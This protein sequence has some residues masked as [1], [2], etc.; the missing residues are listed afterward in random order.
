MNLLKKLK[1]FDWVYT[2]VGVALSIVALFLPKSG[3]F[4]LLDVAVD[5]LIIWGIVVY[6]FLKVRKL[7]GGIKQ[8]LFVYV[9]WLFLVLFSLCTTKNFV[10]D[11]I[12]GPKAITLYNV[13]LSMLQ[14]T[15]GL[16]SLHYYLNGSDS[17]GKHHRIEISSWDY[18]NFNR[19]DSFTIT[20]YENTDRLYEMGGVN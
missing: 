1:K 18:N 10:M 8:N 9:V 5:N 3:R 12:S 13:N 6:V 15:K 11:I 17:E 19:P 2:S 4:A 16:I 20:Y 7:S 14:G